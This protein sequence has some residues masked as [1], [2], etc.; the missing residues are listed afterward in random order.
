MLY[1]FLLGVIWQPDCFGRSETYLNRRGPVEVNL[2]PGAG[3]NLPEVKAQ[4]LL[5]LALAWLLLI[6]P[7]FAQEQGEYSDR[8]FWNRTNIMLH[9]ATAAAAAADFYTTR[10]IVSCGGRERNP[11][12]RPFAGSDGAF[13]AYKAASWASYLGISYLFYRK[14]W[15]RLERMFPLVA[16]SADGTA[17]GFNFRLIF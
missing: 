2:G 6:V 1:C 17:V 10:R 11:L 4:F 16:I 3:N 13:A 12:A 5:K 14:G 9:S 15:H 8:K 7:A